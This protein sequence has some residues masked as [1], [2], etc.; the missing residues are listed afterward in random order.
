MK[1][2]IYL[3]IFITSFSIGLAQTPVTFKGAINSKY[4]IEMELREDP[5]DA[6]KVVG[7]YRYAGKTAYLN[8]K[9]DSYS[10]SVLHLTESYDGKTTGEFYL[11]WEGENT[12]TGTWMGGE[13]HFPVSLTRLSGDREQLD[14]YDITVISAQTNADITGSY[15]SETH[16]INDFHSTEENPNLEIGFN[17]GVVTVQEVSEEEI[18]VFFNLICGPTYHMAYFSGTAKK[19]GNRQYEFNQISEFG[20]E[21]PCHLIFTFTE[22]TISIEQKS[23]SFDC[24][25]GARAYADGDFLKVNNQ[26]IDEEDPSVR[27]ALGL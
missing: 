2:Y 1:K 8:L 22:K 5:N 17:G 7:K 3:L 24:G 27:D 21:E 4:Q 14:A 10:S 9:G 18:K 16:W 15:V 19:T 20:G 25:F 6:G 11:E 13:K 26:V 12:L 23:A